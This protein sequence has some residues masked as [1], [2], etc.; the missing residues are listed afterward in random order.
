MM[1]NDDDMMMMKRRKKMITMDQFI[2]MR[3]EDEMKL[4]EDVVKLMVWLIESGCP[5]NGRL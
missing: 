3:L 1:K 5:V 4:R 2:A